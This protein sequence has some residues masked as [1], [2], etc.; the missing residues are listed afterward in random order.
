MAFG[1]LEDNAHGAFG[2]YRGRWLGTIGHLGTLSFH[3]T[4]NVQ[5]GQGGALLIDFSPLQ[6]DAEVFRDK[7]TNRGA[8]QRGKV[9]KYESVSLGSSYVMANILA[10]FLSGQLECRQV[11]ARSRRLRWTRYYEV[12]KPWA[13]RLGIDLPNPPP[14]CEHKPCLLPRDDQPGCP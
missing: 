1:W 2:K 5:C 12:L 7:G 6:V 11:A 8:Y 13:N 4:K 10:A 14:H 3:E 9:D